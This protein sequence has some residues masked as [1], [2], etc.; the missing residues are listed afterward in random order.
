MKKLSERKKTIL[1]LVVRE[2]IDSGQAVGSKSLV[3]KYKLEAYKDEP[4]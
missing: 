3:K 4:L 1:L 2:Y